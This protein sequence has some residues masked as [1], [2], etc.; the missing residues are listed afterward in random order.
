MSRRG[1]K[2]G[3]ITSYKH[4]WLLK[5]DGEGCVWISDAIPCHTKGSDSRA[6]VT[7]VRR[8]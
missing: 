1:H 8:R 7:E 6:S 5:T 4:T 3:T 2:T